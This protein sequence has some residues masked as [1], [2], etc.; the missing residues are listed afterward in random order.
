MRNTQ[1]IVTV[2]EKPQ[3]L[4]PSHLSEVVR[5]ETSAVPENTHV[6]EKTTYSTK[7]PP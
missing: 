6:Q 1:V 5:K 2:V 4:N 3:A 7:R